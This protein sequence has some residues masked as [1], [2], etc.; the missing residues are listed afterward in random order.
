MTG[1]SPEY[2]IREKTHRKTAF[3]AVLQCVLFL[4]SSL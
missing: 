3:K 4:Q 1:E 2:V